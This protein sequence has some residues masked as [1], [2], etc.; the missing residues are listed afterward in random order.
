MLLGGGVSFQVILWSILISKPALGD[1]PN[2]NSSF[3]FSNDLLYRSKKLI[4]F[5]S[6]F[7]GYGL[8]SLSIENVFLYSFFSTFGS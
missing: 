5:P 3:G 2:F 7:W 8:V 6:G 4:F 1:G